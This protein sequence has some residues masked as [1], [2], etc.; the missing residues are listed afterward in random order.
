LTVS[1]KTESQASGRTE[2]LQ[3][4]PRVVDDKVNAIAMGLLE[5]LR[6]CLYT[7]TARY[8]QG[9]IFD[10]RE[11]TISRQSVGLLQLVILVELANS[12][13]PS[14]LVSSREVYEELPIVKGGLGVLQGELSD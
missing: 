14:A 8:I 12:S 7:L 9:R 1:L 5:V 2:T 10:L 11:S 13:F 3:R 4:D 6:E